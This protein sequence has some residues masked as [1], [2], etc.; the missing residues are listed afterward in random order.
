MGKKTMILEQEEAVLAID[1]QPFC[2]I[3]TRRPYGELG[4][5][6]QTSCLCCTGVSS[7]L[8]QSMPLFIGWG[9]EYNKVGEIVQ[10][11]KRRMKARGD[12]GQIAKTEAALKELHELRA[13]MKELKA[14]MKLV[15]N[16]LKVPSSSSSLSSS[17]VGTSATIER[18]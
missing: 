14:D 4:S 1:C 10:E 17:G 16:A 8:S 6:D 7:N 15:L 9:C 3:E 2:S 13:E 18:F 5:V 11:L 12:T